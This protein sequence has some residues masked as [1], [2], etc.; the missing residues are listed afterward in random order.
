MPKATATIDFG[1]PIAF[2]V[3]ALL[4]GALGGA[5]KYMRRRGGRKN[6]LLKAVLG[7]ALIGLIVAVAYYAVNESAVFALGMLGAFLGIKTSSATAA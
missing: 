4:G 1:W 7:G 5:G 6:Q 3:A 2:L